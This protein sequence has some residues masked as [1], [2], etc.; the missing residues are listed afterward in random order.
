M[1]QATNG[2]E[3]VVC[4]V[5]DILVFG[6]MQKEHN[7]HLEAVMKSLS[8][9]G[10]TLNE[11]KCAFSQKQVQY[12]GHV[13]NK[14]G[15]QPDPSKVEAI[16]GMEKPR[17]PSDI[18]R[19]LGMVNHLGKFIP[20]FATTTKALRDLLVQ[21]NDWTW[22]RVQQDA[23]RD[24]KEMLQSDV[25]LKLYD[26]NKETLVSADSSSIGLGAILMQKQEGG[27]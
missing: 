6:K 27:H 8:K 3:G 19:F 20:H 24:L 21:S 14:N 25:V 9:A 4:Q 16:A 18:G 1:A 5:D 10:I 26:P 17:D 15:V 13:I 7:Q 22:G 2:L 12:L 11:S 23:F